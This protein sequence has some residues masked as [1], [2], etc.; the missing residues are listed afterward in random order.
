MPIAD[1]QST[2]L[3][4]TFGTPIIPG[5]LNSQFIN[6]DKFKRVNISFLVHVKVRSQIGHEVFRH[7]ILIP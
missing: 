3:S 6:K 2:S 4:L 1:S 5:Q 7:L